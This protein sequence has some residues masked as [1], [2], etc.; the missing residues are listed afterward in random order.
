M[1]IHFEL[2]ALISLF[3]WSAAACL[4]LF[5]TRRLHR[6]AEILSLIGIASLLYFTISLWILLDRPPLRTLGET[7]LW[8]SLFLSII[9]YVIYKRW[10]YRIFF[11]YALAMALLFLSI[12]YVRPDI[13]SKALMPALQSVWFVPHVIVYIVGYAF[14]GFATVM[15]IAGLLHLQKKQ[16]T[17][18][19]LEIAENLVYI[20]YGF[21][22]LGLLFGALWAKEA[23]G[24]YWTWDPKETWA[25]LTWGVYLVWMHLSI[26]KTYT[27]RFYFLFLCIA[28][29]V[30]LLAWF[31]VNYLP[32]AQNS[33]H[34]YS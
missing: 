4:F 17:A 21:V 15:G 14:L 29:I 31:G 2:F 12:N 10:Q 11:V 7:R 25:L 22:T 33:V 20:G 9:G 5:R 30:L 1:W 16:E 3:T 24:H 19:T 27:H 13:H 23:W 34:V 6:I 8:Y 32:A 18:H 26:K 28:F